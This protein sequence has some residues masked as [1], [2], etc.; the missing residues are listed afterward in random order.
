MNTIVL[1]AVTI[2][3]ILGVVIGLLLGISSIVLAVKVDEREVAVY[4]AL[5][6]FNCGACGFPGC[7][8][9]AKGLMNSEVPIS[10]CKP[11]KP[12]ARDAIKELLDSF[13]IA[14]TL[15]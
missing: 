10:N 11:S 4:D 2:I 6:H 5:P 13:D 14:N 7:K 8:G 3:T 1:S 15:K 9:M 12:A